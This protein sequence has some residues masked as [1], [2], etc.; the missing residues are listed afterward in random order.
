MFNTL[1]VIIFFSI[2]IS[3]FVNS[4]IK[5]AIKSLLI[6]S[7]EHLADK[8]LVRFCKLSHKI[9]Q[10]LYLF[11]R[12]GVVYTRAHTTDTAMTF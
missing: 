10:T 4:T 3:L 7:V 6:F 8:Y 5:N 11:E 1:N 2:S 12:D 9:N